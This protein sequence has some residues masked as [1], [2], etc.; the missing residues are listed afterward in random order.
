M[1]GPGHAEKKIINAAN[2]NGQIVEEIAASRPI[3]VSCAKD[4]KDAGAIPVSPLKGVMV[5]EPW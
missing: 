5:D 4:I 1:V 3:C 2:R